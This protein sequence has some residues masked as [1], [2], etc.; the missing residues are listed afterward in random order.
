MYVSSV[1][2]IDGTPVLDIK[3]YIPQY[4][5]PLG[6]LASLNVA[7]SLSSTDAEPHDQEME[8]EAFLPECLQDETLDKND[9]LN[10]ELDQHKQVVTDSCIS[11]NGLEDPPVIKKAVIAGWLEKPPI[12]DLKVVFTERCEHDLCDLQTSLASGLIQPKF[13]KSIEEA[14]ESIAKILS[15]DP[16]ST[17][18]RTKT[19]DRLYFF[20]VDI[21]HVTSWFDDEYE[22]AEVLKIKVA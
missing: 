17:Y 16:R 18:R 5:Q 4:D 3:P 21:F 2:L 1:D 14:K 7:E 12:S 11:A 20:N 6:T 10:L 8:T 22:T 19:S 15:N 9:H 13:L